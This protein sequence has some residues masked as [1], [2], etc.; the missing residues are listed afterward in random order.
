ML[1]LVIASAAMMHLES[2]AGR[3][4]TIVCIGTSGGLFSILLV[5]IWPRFFGRK[6]LGKIS[7]INMMTMTSASA[8]GP[9]LFAQSEKSTGSYDA[10]FISCAAAAGLLLLA[11]LKLKNPAEEACADTKPGSR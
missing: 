7:S 3:L 4:L 8:L 2:G 5:V 1:A 11:A 10:A 6:H 9:W